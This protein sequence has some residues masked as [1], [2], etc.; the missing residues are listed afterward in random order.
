MEERINLIKEKLTGNYKEDVEYLTTLYN[1]QYRVLEDTTAT[2]E[3]ITTVLKEITDVQENNEKVEEEVVKEEEKEETSTEEN[4][5]APAKEQVPQENNEID[6]L[7][8]ELTSNLENESDEEALKSIEKI[9]PKIESISKS[10]DENTIYCSFTNDFEK[11]IFENIFGKD[12]QIKATPYA[13]DVVYIMY[14]DLLLKKKKRKAAMDALDRAI[15]WNFLNREARE[16]K[17]DLYYSRQEIVKCLETIK[18]LQMIS[19]TAQDIADCYNKYAFVF[20]SLKDT[21]SAYALYRLSYSYYQNEEVLKI[22]N[23]IE[24]K[25]PEYKQIPANDLI[26]LA[27]D[28]DVNIGPNANIIKAH[29]DITTKLI[30][31][32][33]IK[34]AKFMIENDYSMTRDEAIAK[35][36]DQLNE[37]DNTNEIK[38]EPKEED[39]QEK[40]T[41]RKRKKVAKETEEVKDE[42]EEKEAT[43]KKST[44]RKTTKVDKK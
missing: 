19:Y 18:K 22:I 4:A 16:K 31:V 27:R 34:E 6:A 17:I 37:L 21:K 44:R 1:A 36:Y 5:E 38:E 33:A 39:H 40:K 30:E 26:Q 15:Y 23:D 7:I 29:R 13:N 24:E 25:E 43:T 3:A 11:M 8:D 35:I 41:T 2:I 20:N 10:E 12:K 42:K 14:S 32:G 28:N 9:I